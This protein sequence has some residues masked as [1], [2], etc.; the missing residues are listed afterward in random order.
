MKKHKRLALIITLVVASV[1]LTA[2]TIS[3]FESLKK[4]YSN[5]NEKEV[6]LELSKKSFSEITQEINSISSYDTDLSNLILHS[7][8]LVERIDEISDD[9]LLS[10]IKDDKS[11]VNLKV[12]MVQ[13]IKYK[14]S[15]S[16]IADET[17]LKDLLMNDDTD[18]AIKQNIIWA[19]SEDDPKTV[20]LLKEISKQDDEL[21]A[22]QAI[23]KLNQTEPD[24]AIDISDDIL[25]HYDKQQPEKVR[26]AIK[27]KA[28]QLRQDASKGNE[29]NEFIQ[30]LLDLFKGT[31]D[32]VM[33]DTVVFALSDLKDEAAISIIVLNKDIEDS[34]KT[35]CIDQNYS[36]LLRMVKNNP[37]DENIE[38]VIQAMNIYPIKDLVSPLKEVINK[39]NSRISKGSFSELIEQEGNPVNEKWL[40]QK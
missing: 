17:V 13:L 37:T 22:F 38:T 31:D 33:K 15:S 9:T 36:T 26:A 29:K 10:I 21:L 1:L 35:Y 18:S 27:V 40:D 25:N 34:I 6:S 4:D 30:M 7:S 3:P 20:E 23:K 11:S 2:F 24:I 32:E 5:K 14:N 8:A 39:S 28:E 12:I 16:G 19:L